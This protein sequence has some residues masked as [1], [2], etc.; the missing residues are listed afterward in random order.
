M[1]YRRRSIVLAEV[2]RQCRYILK[3]YR[4]TAAAAATRDEASLWYALDALLIGAA[5]LH[6]LL[7]PRPNPAVAWA[8][9]LRAAL[10]IGIDSPL[11]NKQLESA[12]DLAALAD[13][14]ILRP[15]GGPRWFDRELSALRYYGRVFELTPLLI[16]VADLEARAAREMRHMREMV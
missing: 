16:A 6:Q 14:W 1:P 11:A 8:A 3:A 15:D 10:A 2:E 4:E 9:E 12:L 5:R 13:E 7:W